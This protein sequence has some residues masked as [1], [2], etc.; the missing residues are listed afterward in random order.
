VGADIL[1]EAYDLKLSTDRSS[2]LPQDQAMHNAR[3]F[4]A[5]AIHQMPFLRADVL[6]VDEV[7]ENIAADNV[8]RMYE[9]S[10]N[11]LGDGLNRFNYEFLSEATA[12]PGSAR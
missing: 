1:E 12:T 4:Y 9:A 5:N 3:T 6:K 7:F 10:T 2:I 11:P 8:A